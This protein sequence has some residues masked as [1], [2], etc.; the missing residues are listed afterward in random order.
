MVL[1]WVCLVFGVVLMVRMLFLMM[2]LWNGFGCIL[3]VLL[4]W[5]WLIWI[6]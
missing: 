4:V 2:L 5:W 6:V 1:F 3:I